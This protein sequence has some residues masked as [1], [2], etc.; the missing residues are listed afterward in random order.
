V[1]DCP[2]NHLLIFGQHTPEYE[3]LINRKDRAIA[4]LRLDLRPGVVV[5]R[6]PYFFAK[7]TREKKKCPGRRC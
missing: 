2:Q 4:I 6:K 1:R 5:G 3:N 7:Q